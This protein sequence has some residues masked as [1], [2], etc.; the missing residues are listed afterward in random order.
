VDVRPFKVVAAPLRSYYALE[1]PVGAIAGSE[2]HVGDTVEF[3]EAAQPAPSP[4]TMEAWRA[5]S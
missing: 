5:A 1:L 3:A 4:E 2:T